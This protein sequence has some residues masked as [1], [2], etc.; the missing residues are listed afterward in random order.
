MLIILSRFKYNLNKGYDR[1]D[2]SCCKS[3]IIKDKKI[4]PKKI[5]S[6]NMQKVKIDLKEIAEEC[7]VNKSL[8][9]KVEENNLIKIH[10]YGKSPR[11]TPKPMILPKQINIDEEFVENIGMYIGDGTLSPKRKQTEF[12]T[13]DIDMAKKYL[14]FLRKTF[15]LAIDDMTFIVKYRRGRKREVKKKWANILEIPEK[16]IIAKKENKYKIQENMA[17]IVNSIIFTFLFKKIIE[18]LLPIIKEN[19]KL[20]KAFLRGEFASDGKFVIEK[21]IKTYYISEI[22]FCFNYKK[23]LWLKNYLISCLKLEGMSKINTNRPGFIRIT[24]WDNYF[25]LW[26]MRI[27]DCCQRKKNKFLFTL[28]QSHIY[29]IIGSDVINSIVNSINLQKKVIANKIN[30]NRTNLFRVLKGKQLLTIEQ[31]N[32]LTQ[33]INKSPKN[34]YNQMNGIRIGKITYLPFSKKFIDFIIKEKFNGGD[35]I[36]NCENKASGERSEE[37]R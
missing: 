22:T 2:L 6:D 29:P 36:A 13:I 21:D 27:F 34:F 19:P 28:R 15:N 7:F 8:I 35:K 24:G 30:I 25:K 16:K 33:L 20:R 37:V 12:T 10:Y 23:E 11:N 5:K 18:K 32:N 31:F 14:R 26:Q 17:I 3:N 4:N 9:E 1:K